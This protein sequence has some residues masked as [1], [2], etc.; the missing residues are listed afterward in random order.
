M[1]ALYSILSLLD[2]NKID[3]I[4]NKIKNYTPLGLGIGAMVALASYALV[5]LFVVVKQ[6][7]DAARRELDKSTNSDFLTKQ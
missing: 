4:V 5:P 3:N 2:S 6:K 7:N 1:G